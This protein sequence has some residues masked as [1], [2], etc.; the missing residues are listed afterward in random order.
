MISLSVARLLKGCIVLLVLLALLPFLGTL[1]SLSGTPIN[2]PLLISRPLSN[3]TIWSS[4]FHISPV[5]DIKDV[6]LP[7][8]ARLVDKSLSGHCHLTKTCQTDL[9]VIDQAN[10]IEL[11]PCPNDLHREFYDSYVGDEEF[12]R[13]DA[14]LCTH[15]CSMCELFMSFGKP[16]IV[17]ASTRYEIGR[18]DAKRWAEWNRNLR[19]IASHPDN[20]IAANNKYDLE[21]IKYFTGIKNVEY[22]PSYCG[23]VKAAYT[24]TRPAVLIAPGRGT[25]SLLVSKLLSV[26]SDAEVV[27]KPMR[28]LYPA[29]EYSDLASHP[30]FV[31]M[32]YQISFM[33][34]FE[35]YRMGV[36][37]FAPSPELLATWHVRR[38]VL[39]ERT[40]TSALYQT[41]SRQS[42]IPRHPQSTSTLASDPNADLDY[43]AVLEWIK[44]A[45][46]YQFPHVTTF[47]S[48]EHLM[49]LIKSTDLKAISANMNI[50]NVQQK[51]YITNK[52]EGILHTVKYGKD[53]YLPTFSLRSEQAE[54]LDFEA[55]L[56]QRYNA[57]LDTEDCV[58]SFD[59]DGAA[60]G[61]S[62]GS[63]ITATFPSINSRSESMSQDSATSPPAGEYANNN[64]NRNSLNSNHSV[65]PYRTYVT[66]YILTVVGLTLIVYAMYCAP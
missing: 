14:I 44:L 8:G 34:F 62:Y 59:V 38:N 32:P 61:R 43:D 22:L 10:G 48:F 55:A 6:L 41:P 37:M 39:G 52:W 2:F 24:P 11:S 47:A 27:M 28:D 26:A 60:Y 66:L 65:S 46:F 51:E 30:A 25:N 49:E 18:I 13:T 19:R 56:A 33:L 35:L 54:P 5:A 58:G 57:K 21:Y 12:Q 3:I 63:A 31:L 15:A 53:S 23:Y 20:I 9:R 40:W 45:D 7:L 29:Y 4:D 17:I 42:N 50:F 36:P 16:L 64:A 1:F